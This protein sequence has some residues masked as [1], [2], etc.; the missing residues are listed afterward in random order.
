MWS[1][2]PQNWTSSFIAFIVLYVDVKLGTPIAPERTTPLLTLLTLKLWKTVKINPREDKIKLSESAREVR[3]GA[4][5]TSARTRP[6]QTPED[7]DLT[8]LVQF[9]CLKRLFCVHAPHA[10][11]GSDIE[12]EFI[13]S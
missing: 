7:R 1:G 2:H 6:R 4:C 9:L 3:G 12:V 8:V 13:S 11:R 10:H 5:V